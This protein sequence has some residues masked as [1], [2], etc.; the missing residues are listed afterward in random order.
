M[1]TWQYE[2]G[3]V[4][5]ERDKNSLPF[6]AFMSTIQRPL[7]MRAMNATMTEEMRFPNLARDALHE[8]CWNLKWAQ[9]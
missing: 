3:R 2:W 4:Q 5:W 6:R 8:A 7:C 9:D 1:S